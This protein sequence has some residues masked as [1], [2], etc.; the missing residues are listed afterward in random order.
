MDINKIEC[1]DESNL[2]ISEAVIA[3][4]ASTAA[5]DVEGVASLAASSASQSVKRALGIKGE[6]KG[7]S[8]TVSDGEVVVDL[9]IDVKYGVNVKTTAENVQSSVRS[10]IENMTGMVV[11]KVDVA[12]VGLVFETENKGKQED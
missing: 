6:A 3:K 10:A 2:K 12:V 5:T 11:A 4:I 7:V 1:S 8:V 9:F